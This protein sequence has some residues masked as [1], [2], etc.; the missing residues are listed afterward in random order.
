MKKK[1]PVVPAVTGVVIV[2]AGLAFLIARTQQDSPDETR[3]VAVTGDALSPFHAG[4]PD[5]AVGRIAPTLLGSSFDGSPVTVQP[6]GKPKLVLFLAHWC[7]HCQREVPV[8]VRWL[9][10]RG[11][12]DG[13]DIMAIATA[14]T[15]GADNFPPSKWL[16]R[17]GLTVPV[18][19]DDNKSSA[20]TAFG[21]N[22]YPYFVRARRGGQG[23]GA[24]AGELTEQELDE[25]AGALSG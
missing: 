22:G 23:S 20:G 9:D 8:V 2:V 11:V 15:P 24:A 13:F 17:E 12:P 1:F 19:A 7:P 14:T 6:D 21:V 4:Q 25:L 3:P 5:D 10:D 16:K 18:M